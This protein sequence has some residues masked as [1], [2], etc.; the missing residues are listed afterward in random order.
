MEALRQIHFL[1]SK[2]IANFDKYKARRA[3]YCSVAKHKKRKI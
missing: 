3:G 2:K 1:N